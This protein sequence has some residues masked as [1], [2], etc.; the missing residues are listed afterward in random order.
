MPMRQ[1]WCRAHGT[2]LDPAGAV[3]LYLE[4]ALNMV[5]A[6]LA[7]CAIGA[8]RGYHGRPAGLRTH[9]LV[10]LASCVLMLLTLHQ[11][12]WFD[13]GTTGT[14]TLDPTRMALGIMTGIGFL[15]AGVLMGVGFFSAGVLATLLTLAVLVVLHHIEDRLPAVVYARL[16][17]RMRRDEVLHEAALRELLAGHHCSIAHLSY[18]LGAGDAFEYRLML[19]TRRAAHLAALARTLGAFEAVQQFSLSTAGD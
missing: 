11:G 12:H 13:R 15:G 7:G 2:C 16:V 3:R 14:V 10:C 19:R 6:L 8:E 17:V 5:A 18:R 1:S 4:V 9:A